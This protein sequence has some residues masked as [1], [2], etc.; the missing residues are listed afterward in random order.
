M[1]TKIILLLS[2]SGFGLSTVGFIAWTF[3]L[4]HTWAVV[5]CIGGAMLSLAFI[6]TMV[7]GI[8]V[9]YIENHE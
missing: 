8:Y 3:T 4:S 5:G 2:L 9:E 7:A 6:A 1:I